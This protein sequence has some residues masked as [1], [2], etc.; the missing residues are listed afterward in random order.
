[1]QGA[2]PLIQKKIGKKRREN[3]GEMNTGE[4]ENV[5]NGPISLVH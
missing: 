2:W 4:L 5:A 1:M 3:A